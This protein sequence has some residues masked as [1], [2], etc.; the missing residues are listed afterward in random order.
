MRLIGLAVV[1]VANLLWAP[2]AAR[3]LELARSHKLPLIGGWGPWAQG[4]ALFSYG[5]DL[6]PIVRLAATYVDKILKGAK[7]RGSSGRAAHEA[8]LDHQF[9][10]CEVFG[11]AI[12]QTL[13][14]RADRVIE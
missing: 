1:L 13:V 8:R 11:L 3:I 9:H 2:F 4:G 12:P 10:D 14:Q 5:P 7:P 6:D